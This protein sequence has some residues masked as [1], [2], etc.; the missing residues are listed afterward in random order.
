MSTLYETINEQLEDKSID[1]AKVDL[2]GFNTTLGRYV[3]FEDGSRRSVSD[4]DYWVLDDNMQAMHEDWLRFVRSQEEQ[5]APQFEGDKTMLEVLQTSMQTGYQNLKDA[6]AIAFEAAEDALR[7]RRKLEIAHDDLLLD[8]GLD[9][10]NEAI[11]EAQARR[12]LADKYAA[13]EMAENVARRAKITV[14][15]YRLDVE[16]LRAQLRIAEVKVA[17]A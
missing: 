2:I 15:Y 8:G 13:V 10:K 11:R 3:G 16:A 14:E 4:H 7:A 12:T 5:P 9:G 1:S 17:A 6:T